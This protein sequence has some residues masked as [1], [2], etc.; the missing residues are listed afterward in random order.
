MFVILFREISELAPIVLNW[1]LVPL[2]NI[3]MAIPSLLQD[4][5][6]S[7]AFDKNKPFLN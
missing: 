3:F 6:Q 4:L 5:G 7:H 1:I 2:A